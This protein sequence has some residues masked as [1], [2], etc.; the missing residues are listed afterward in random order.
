MQLEI[1]EIVLLHPNVASCLWRGHGLPE[2]HNVINSF[3][4]PKCMVFRIKSYIQGSRGII[5]VASLDDTIT[6]YTFEQYCIGQERKHSLCCFGQVRKFAFWT[7]TIYK[8]CVCG[9]ANAQIQ[10]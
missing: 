1:G 10:T 5:E 4:V 7:T 9:K 2:A 8:C 3:P 6:G